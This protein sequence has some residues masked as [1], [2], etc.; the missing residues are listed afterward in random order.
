[1]SRTAADEVDTPA[2]FDCSQDQ[3]GH[4]R[5]ARTDSCRIDLEAGHVGGAR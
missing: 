3:R 1:M 2:N 4:H 5:R